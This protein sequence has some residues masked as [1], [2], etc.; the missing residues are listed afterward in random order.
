MQAHCV[1][2]EASLPCAGPFKKFSER[3][4]GRENQLWIFA[5]FLAIW[6]EM[7]SDTSW[8]ELADDIL[9]E[10]SVAESHFGSSGE[11]SDGEDN[12]GGESDGEESDGGLN[13]GDDDDDATWD[14]SNEDVDVPVFTGKTG[15]QVEPP[16]R[17]TPLRFSS[18]FSLRMLLT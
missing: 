16:V 11:D 10:G 7:L 2:E 13:G 4:F 1:A 14:E 17:Q 18:C 3:L 9:E 8:Y 15:L 6:R 5:L 12:E